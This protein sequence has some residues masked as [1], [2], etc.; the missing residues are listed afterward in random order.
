M[1]TNPATT[2]QN[3][4]PLSRRAVGWP[5]VTGIVTLIHWGILVLHIPLFTS[6]PGWFWPFVS[7]L[8]LIPLFYVA[9]PCLD[10][11]RALLRFGKGHRAVLLLILTLQGVTV[12]LTKL[13]QDFW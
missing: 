10:A 8:V 13:N 5:I 4:S 12:Y 11:D 1:T 6:L 3:E 7:Y 9:R 2:P